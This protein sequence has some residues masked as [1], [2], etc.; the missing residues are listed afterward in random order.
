MMRV[1]FSYAY[2]NSTSVIVLKYV[3]LVK[4]SGTVYTRLVTFVRRHAQEP[5]RGSDVTAHNI[6]RLGLSE[7]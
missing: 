2:G 7:P 5:A 1:L 3:F 4:Y 6:Q